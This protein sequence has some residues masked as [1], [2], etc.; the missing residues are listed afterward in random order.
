MPGDTPSAWRTGRQAIQFVLGIAVIV[1]ALAN[2]GPNVP[3]LVVGLI[4]LGLLSV[5]DVVARFVARIT[6]RV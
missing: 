6:G 1:D 5:E 3:E 2:P 4:L